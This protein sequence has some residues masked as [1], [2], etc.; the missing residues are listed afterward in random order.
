MTHSVSIDFIEYQGIARILHH[1][2]CQYPEQ[3]LLADFI[4]HQVATSWPEFQQR[5]ANDQGRAALCRYLNQWQPNQLVGLQ[6]DYGQLFFGPGEPK[7]IPQGS[8]YLGEEQLLNDRSTVALIDFYKAHGVSLSLAYSQP[9]DHIGLFFSVLDTGLGR[10]AD[11]PENQALIQFVQV[12]LQ[13]H[14]LPWSGRCLAL[15]A[16]HAQTDFYLAIALLADD[17][18]NQLA[19]DFQV[20][21]MPMRLFR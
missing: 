7:A 8:V 17:F 13:Q 19:A 2:L 18:L 12:L 9:L 16:Q 21:P 15:A 4:E 10:L 11:E 20:V 5:P 1:V 14:L 3:Q 6:L